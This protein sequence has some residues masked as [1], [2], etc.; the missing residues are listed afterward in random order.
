MVYFYLIH[1]LPWGE[2]LGDGKRNVRTLFIGAILYILT[3]TFLWSSAGA[4]FKLFRN[5][6]FWIF[7]ADIVTMGAIYK[8][9]YGESMLREIGWYSHND[10]EK[11]PLSTVREPASEQTPAPVEAPSNLYCV[12]DPNGSIRCQEPHDDQKD[13]KDQ[14]D[15][16]DR[17]QKRQ[18]DLQE[19]YVVPEEEQY[20]APE[21]EQYPEQDEAQVQDEAQE[22]AEVQDQ[23]QYQEQVPVEPQNRDMDPEH[24][25]AIEEGNEEEDVD[26]FALPPP[27][28]AMK[29]I[30]ASGLDEDTTLASPEDDMIEILEASEQDDL[31]FDSEKQ[32]PK[33]VSDND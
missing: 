23:E 29:I 27:G 22:Q 9:Y 10:G 26:M 13:Q 21:E 6:L 1:N 2:S 14:K 28:M 19:Q 4:P 18:N 20:V 33:I 24:Y 12:R 32:N 17:D 3:H 31:H 15:R 16:V 8:M 7:V 11:E 25:I 30:E 5:Y